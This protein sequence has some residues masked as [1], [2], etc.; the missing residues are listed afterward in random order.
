VPRDPVD[1]CGY[2]KPDFPAAGLRILNLAQRL[3]IAAGRG[4][5]A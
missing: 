1:H 2:R 4:P 3:N 5:Y